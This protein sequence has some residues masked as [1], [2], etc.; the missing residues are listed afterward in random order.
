[1]EENSRS[2]SVEE[3]TVGLFPWKRTQSFSFHGREHIRS[4]SMEENSRS[5]S[6]EENTVGFNG[7]MHS[8]LLDYTF[9]LMT[10]TNT[11][12]EPLRL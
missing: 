12:P 2:V 5:V 3:N 11:I 6:V 4:V 1:M 10:V 8:V 9:H 7:R